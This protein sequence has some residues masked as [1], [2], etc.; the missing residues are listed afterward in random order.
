MNSFKRTHLTSVFVLTLLVAAAPRAASAQ[1]LDGRAPV[2]AIAAA[3]MPS[4]FVVEPRAPE[5]PAALLPLYVSFAALQALDAA[6]T[7]RALNSGGAEANPLMASVVG[8]PAVF[9]GVKAAA[10][11]A[12]IVA[13]ERLWKNH[14]AAAI[15]TMIGMNIGYSMVVA[16]NFR[17]GGQ[18][19]Q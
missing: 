6:S 12:A 14:R 10:S 13:A 11:A 9:L 15:A 2:A 3:G 16:H 5:R 4:P 19:L 17:V 1:S 8:S 7:M 18:R